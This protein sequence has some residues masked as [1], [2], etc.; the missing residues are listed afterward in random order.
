MGQGCHT[1]RSISDPVYPL[2]SMHIPTAPLMSTMAITK[3][4]SCDYRT[5]SSSSSSSSVMGEGRAS[6]PTS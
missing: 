1:L 4:V 3:T 6:L 2:G 5:C